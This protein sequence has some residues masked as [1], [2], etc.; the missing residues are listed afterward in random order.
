MF[1][2]LPVSKRFFVII[3]GFLFLI[4]LILLKISH[5]IYT[6]MLEVRLDPSQQSFYQAD[7]LKLKTDSI[8]STA[9][10]IILFG[11]SRIQMWDEIPHIDGLEFINRG[12]GGQTTGQA[13]L[14]VENDILAINADA[15]VLQLGINDLKAIAFSPAKR[16]RIIKTVQNNLQ[17]IIETLLAHDI[18]VYLMTVIPASSPR[19][20]WIFLWSDEIDTS[21]AIVNNWIKTIDNDGVYILDPTKKLTN[22]LKT[23]KEFSLDTL[24]LN[25]TG[26]GILNNMLKDTFK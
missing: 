4:S 25:E 2:K 21:V 17:N 24:H 7:N 18:D 5:S 22:G 16:D 10:R 11:D 6:Q 14:R 3:S 20:G 19:G 1:S 15:V 9:Y 13:R 23:N 12:I 8:N 26:Y